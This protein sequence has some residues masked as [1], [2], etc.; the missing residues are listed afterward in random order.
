MKLSKILFF[1]L[2]PFFSALSQGSIDNLEYLSNQPVLDLTNIDGSKSN[3]ILPLEFS[4]RKYCPTPIDQGIQESC[5]GYAV[6]Y[7][8]QTIR[9]TYL[10]NIT[11]RKEIDSIAF[12]PYFIYNQVKLLECDFGSEI[13]DALH[14]LSYAGNVHH[15]RFPSSSCKEKPTKKLLYEASENKIQDWGLI[16]TP[17][18]ESI[19]NLE[20]V[21]LSL[22]DGYPVIISMTVY[23]SFVELSSKNSIWR[24]YPN[25]SPKGSGHALVIVGY[26]DSTETFEL[27]NSWGNNWG[28]GGFAKIKYDDFSKNVKYAFRFYEPQKLQH[29]LS[30]KFKRQI[31]ITS[32]NEVLYKEERMKYSNE[33]GYTDVDNECVNGSEYKIELQHSDKNYY[34]YILN[35]N[36]NERYDLLWKSDFVSFNNNEA[37]TI[38]QQ[39]PDNKDGVIKFTNPQGEEF[40]FLST[41]IEIDSIIADL[42]EFNSLSKIKAYLDENDYL[43]SE[44]R[45]S[46]NNLGYICDLEK[47]KIVML[48]VVFCY[49]D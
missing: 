15:N 22:L 35:K 29:S 8:A 41:R 18:S 38:G 46:Y 6:G 14:L 32:H 49:E 21:K 16:M 31:G 1:L 39:L 36:P 9:H 48:P 12:S 43:A 13:I 42:L 17:Q 27:M 34:L 47:D 7:A 5:T 33:N 4:L 45:F 23:T 2:V 10:N 25:E 24:P 26:D 19:K 30:V 37:S 3:T 40:I 44:P 11:D 20:S 28:N